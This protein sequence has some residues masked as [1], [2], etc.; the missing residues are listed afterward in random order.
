MRAPYGFGTSEVVVAVGHQFNI[1]TV[2]HADMFDMAPTM[3]GKIITLLGLKPLPDTITQLK[4]VCPNLK[5]TLFILDNV[6]YIFGNENTK[7][8]FENTVKVLMDDNICRGMKILCATQ[9]TYG[10]FREFGMEHRLSS[11]NSENSS[12][13]LITLCP[14]LSTNDAKKLAVASM[15][16]PLAIHLIKD[17]YISGHT[18]DDILSGIEEDIGNIAAVVGLETK[19]ELIAITLHYIRSQKPKVQNALKALSFVFSGSFDEFAARALIPGSKFVKHD[20][21]TTLNGS[22]LV[23]FDNLQER[24]SIHP[25]YRK[26]VKDRNMITADIKQTSYERY[27]EYFIQVIHKASILWF[28][29]YSMY[30]SNGIK[31]LRSEQHNIFN[32]FKMSMH[33]GLHLNNRS[34]IQLLLDLTVINTLD[35]FFDQ[36]VLFQFYSSLQDTV[37]VLDD[38]PSTV[39]L[40]YSLDECLDRL[41]VK[42]KEYSTKSSFKRGIRRFHRRR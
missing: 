27:A 6:D 21:L 1:T 25:F 32:L 7:S 16:I 20:I 14:K 30:S 8:D 19:K 28:S 2:V 17:L 41:I 40:R 34:S 37:T 26:L 33:V 42:R 5:S 4:T 10:V 3:S 9:Q 29:K 15:G 18:P 11:L 24:F 39:S 36:K 38:A 22:S 12:K 23:F 13:L 35:E 31:I